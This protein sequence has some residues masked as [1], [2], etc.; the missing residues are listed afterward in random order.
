MAGGICSPVVKYCSLDSS[1]Q[2][3]VSSKKRR[4]DT[5]PVNALSQA[6]L[7]ERVET[8]GTVVPLLSLDVQGE[9][10]SKDVSEQGQEAHHPRRRMFCSELGRG[11]ALRPHFR[12]CI[13]P[14]GFL[15]TPARTSIVLSRRQPAPRGREQPAKQNAEPCLRNCC[16]SPLKHPREAVPF[17][18]N[19]SI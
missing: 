17:T 15:I 7:Q 8:F 11:S 6:H 5:C 1:S 14:A 4:K 2:M 16:L 19:A 3:K 9:K 18:P 12:P 10:E 13:S